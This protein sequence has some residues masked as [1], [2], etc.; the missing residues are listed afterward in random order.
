M[1][2]KKPF[3]WLQKNGKYYV[4]MGDTEVG[5]LIRIDNF[6]ESLNEHLEKLMKTIA[7]LEQRKIDG[8]TELS[9]KEDYTDKIEETKQRL[10]TI[11]KK[12]GVKK[13]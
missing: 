12:L 13:K 4:A 3:V 9:K 10:E 2:D 6:L 11:D 8:K 5:T 7:E 1:T